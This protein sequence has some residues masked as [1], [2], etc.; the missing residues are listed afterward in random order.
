MFYEEDDGSE[1]SPLQKMK[2]LEEVLQIVLRRK[3]IIYFECSEKIRACPH[4]EVHDHLYA[5]Q[6]EVESI[7]RSVSMLSNRIQW[8]EEPDSMSS[9]LESE[10][11]HLSQDRFHFLYSFLDITDP[12]SRQIIGQKILQ[13]CLALEKRRNIL[14]DADKEREIPEEH[15][16]V[17]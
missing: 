7:Q 9:D 5:L 12:M 17:E 11:R 15:I 2:I 4:P 10:M 16:P 6:Q 8:A 3:M 1:S 14:F 13:L